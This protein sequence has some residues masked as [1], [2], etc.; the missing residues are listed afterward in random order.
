[1]NP[2]AGPPGSQPPRPWYATELGARFASAIVLG[3]VAL[4]AAYQGGWPFALFWLVAGGA[5]LYEWTKVARVE[6]R[7]ALRA[8]YGAGL[9]GLTA[10]LIVGAP[11]ALAFGLFGLACIVG[12]AI[13]RDSRNRLWGLGGFACA[14]VVTVVPPLVRAHPELGITGLL[15][16]FAVVWTTDVAAYFVGRRVGGPKLWARVSPKKTWSGAVGGLI[17]GV[18]AGLLVALVAQG[19]GW[20]P[21]VSLPIV[22]LLSSLASVVS[23][24]GDLAESALKRRFDVKDSSRLI[25][26]HGGVMDRLDGFFTVAVMVGAVLLAV[27]IAAA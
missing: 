8:A 6:P 12:S 1:M 3:I 16:M 21:V 17:G 18:A 2:A 10:M 26:G 15:W 19:L 13:A 22:V 20:V 4:L 24:A 27:R 7:M 5:I 11:I 25:P 9:G 23:Q 14:A